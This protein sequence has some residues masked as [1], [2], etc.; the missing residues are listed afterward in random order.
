MKNIFDKNWR[1][2]EQIVGC[3]TQGVY[4]RYYVYDTAP[5]TWFEAIQKTWEESGYPY[6]IYVRHI[7][8]LQHYIPREELPEID[9]QRGE[10]LFGKIVF[11]ETIKYSKDNNPELE[12]H[13]KSFNQKLILLG[14][15][16]ALM[17]SSG[18]YGFISK[19]PYRI[20][21]VCK[22]TNSVL[23]QD[24]ICMKSKMG[25]LKYRLADTGEFCGVVALAILMLPLMALAN[26]RREIN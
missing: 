12:R 23:F 8:E 13:E 2:C 10:S 19:Y 26:S 4:K 9:I 16:L 22:L 3:D 7:S 21:G 1:L 17:L 18:V 6:G 20:T 14:I 24:E 11:G 5:F 25:D 15:F